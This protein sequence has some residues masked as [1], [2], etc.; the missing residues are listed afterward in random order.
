MTPAPM[1]NLF[2]YRKHYVG[3]D[4]VFK[5]SAGHWRQVDTA[6]KWF[7]GAPTET[8]IV[9][10]WVEVPEKWDKIDEAKTLKLTQHLYTVHLTATTTTTTTQCHL[11]RC[12][13]WSNCTGREDKATLLS[14]LISNL[15]SFK[16]KFICRWHLQKLWSLIKWH[17]KY[18]WVSL[19]HR[20]APRP[21]WRPC[22][23]GGHRHGSR[24]THRHGPHC[25]PSL[26]NLCMQERSSLEKLPQ[27]FCVSAEFL[28]RSTKR[29]SRT[30]RRYDVSYSDAY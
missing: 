5:T 6:R 18:P 4:T 2:F 10:T 13:Q 15:G 16:K 22:S 19:T 28:L 23:H 3:M 9:S 17:V 14:R 7:P 27:I 1:A 25:H 24:R 12:T 21:H 8:K 30:R 20:G 11:T 29:L 26:S